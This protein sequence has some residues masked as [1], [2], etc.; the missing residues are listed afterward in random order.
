MVQSYVVKLRVL[1][2]GG[3]ARVVGRVD[4]GQHLGGSSIIKKFEFENIIDLGGCGYPPLGLA[5]GRQRLVSWGELA[6]GD[7]L[8]QV[9]DIRQSYS[10]G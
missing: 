3:G 2:D 4:E 5:Q 1:D 10:R 9:P 7:Q 6:D 8:Q